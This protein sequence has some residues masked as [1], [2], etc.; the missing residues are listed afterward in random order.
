MKRYPRETRRQKKRREN[1]ARLTESQKPNQIWVWLKKVR[2][3]GWA[4][5]ACIATLLSYITLK[6]S[7]AI[8]PYASQDPHNPFTEQFSVQNTSAYAI[9]QVEPHCGIENVIVGNGGFRRGFSVVAPTDFV[10]SLD[11]GAK[12]TATCILNQI[13]HDNPSQ[14]RTLDISI[15]VTFK[16]PLGISKCKESYFRGIPAVDQTFIWTHKGDAACHSK[17]K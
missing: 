15:W 8:E 6:P 14:Y 16:I 9:R 5:I 4:V 1:A 10:D 12:T 11:P 13:V 17:P 7:L 2:K 3:V